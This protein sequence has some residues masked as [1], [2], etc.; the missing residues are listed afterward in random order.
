VVT[1]LRDEAHR[2]AIAYHRELRHQRIME[3]RLDEI[4]G[5]GASKKEALLKYF[6]SITRLQRATAQQI[7]EAPGI[8]MKTAELIR[9]ELDKKG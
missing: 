4:P 9:N 7:A 3:S 5:I 6:G 8:G 1:R 2:F